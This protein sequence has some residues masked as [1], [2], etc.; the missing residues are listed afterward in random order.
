M[1]LSAFSHNLD[2]VRHCAG[3]K[4][5]I[6][7]VVKS[8]GY[9]HGMQ[10]IAHEAVRWGVDYLAVARVDEGA[11]LR[12]EGIRTPIL[13]FEIVPQTEVERALTNDLDLTVATFG[14]AE[15]INGVAE[16]LRKKAKIHIKV[17]TGMGRLGVDYSIATLEIERI[18][19]LKWIDLVGVYSHF[20]TSED[21]DQSFAKEQI[22]RFNKV[23]DGLKRLR[24][25]APLVHMANSGAILCLPDSHF[26]MVRP[27]IML[28]GYAPRNGMQSKEPLKPVMT[29]VSNVSF[30]K[31]VE[32]NTSISYGRKYYTKVKTKIASVP[33]GYGDGYS[34]LLT[35]RSHVLIHGK[36]YPCVGTICMDHLMVDVGNAHDVNVGDDVLLLGSE[37]GISAWDIAET[38]GTIPYEVLCW[39]S[40]R[41]PRVVGPRL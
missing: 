9:G 25:E 6:M 4:V 15:R 36:R 12:K 8:N 16:R 21:P 1:S 19:K 32:A 29:L 13:V 33:I 38:L 34:R 30:M 31:T 40:A 35:N 23:L 3:D 20:A 24:I 5:K 39:V 2:V 7:A 41:V 22:G 26:S 18:A 27:G 10:S 11:E 17:D 28:Y 14:F 37:E